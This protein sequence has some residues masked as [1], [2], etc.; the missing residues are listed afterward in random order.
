MKINTAHAEHCTDLINLFLAF[1]AAHRD[2]TDV[3]CASTCQNSLCLLLLAYTSPQLYGHR[4]IIWEMSFVR[5]HF[6]HIWIFLFCARTIHRILR[7]TVIA[8]SD[9]SSPFALSWRSLSLSLSAYVFFLRTS[10]FQTR[11]NRSAPA[12]ARKPATATTT[13]RRRK[14]KRKI[15]V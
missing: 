13:R 12:Q 3:A 4:Q 5:V 15:N 1:A 11:V 10:I 9:T 8:I 7:I 14:N 6:S 2:S